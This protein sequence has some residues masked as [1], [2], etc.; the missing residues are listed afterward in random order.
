MPTG[1]LTPVNKVGRK[2]EVQTLPLHVY[3]LIG[4]STSLVRAGSILARV[5]QLELMRGVTCGTPT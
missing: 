5:V 2:V 1:H 4:R 3:F